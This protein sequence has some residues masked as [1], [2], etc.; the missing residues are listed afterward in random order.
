VL[1]TSGEFVEVLNFR[2]DNEESSEETTGCKVSVYAEFDECTRSENFIEI[3]RFRHFTRYMS[4]T[5][6]DKQGKK[7]RKDACFQNFWKMSVLFFYS[8]AK[9]KIKND[10]EERNA[11]IRESRAGYRCFVRQIPI[12]RKQPFRL[13]L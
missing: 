1:S 7:N 2:E 6:T 13:N 9:E 10:K 4:F 5:P 11:F 3:L 8:K 12:W